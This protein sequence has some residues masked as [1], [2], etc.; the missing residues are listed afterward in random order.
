[1]AS[2][3][4]LDT[5]VCRCRVEKTDKRTNK[6]TS[7]HINAAESPIHVTTAGMGNENILG[8]YG[9]DNQLFAADG[10]CQLQS[11]VTEKLDQIS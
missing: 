9:T 4:I 8:P 5:S 2:L 6:Q 1:M 7:T 3:V 11:H 10:P